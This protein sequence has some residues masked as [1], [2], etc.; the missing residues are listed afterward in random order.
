[1]MAQNVTRYV[2]YETGGQTSFGI[3]DGSTIRQLTGAPYEGGQPTG[4]TVPLA[5]AKL[6]VPIDPERISKVICVVDNYNKPGESRKAP[7]PFLSPKMQTSLI[8][9]GES[10]EIPPESTTPRHEGSLV[11][12]IGREGRNLSQAGALAHVFGVAVG[13]DITEAGWLVREGGNTV[14]D[15]ILGKAI[16]TWGPIGNTIV[17]GLDFTNLGIETKVNGQV[18]A[19]GQTTQ[20]INGIAPLIH[21]IS[22]YC[23]LLPGDLIYTGSPVATAGREFIKPGD[24]V[25]VTIDGVGSL[26]NPVVARKRAD[27]NPFWLKMLA[28]VQR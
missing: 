26:R 19:Q 20:M 17:S 9:D 25:E 18:V 5:N 16:D 2:R 8:T 22:H 21:Y 3:L 6:V 24:T 13:N 15:R 23:T 12:V 11:I 27:P 4:A 10:I 7:H 14:P 1:M 28:G